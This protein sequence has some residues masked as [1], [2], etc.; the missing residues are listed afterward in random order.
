MKKICFFLLMVVSGLL[1]AQSKKS[2]AK[3]IIDFEFVT[4]DFGKV[5]QGKSVSHEFNFTNKGNAPLVLSNVQ[6]GCG[7]TTPEWPK[8]PIM[9]GQKSKIKAI[10]NPGSYKGKFGKG[11][12]VYSNADN[13]SVVLTIKGTVE[14][15]P[16]EPQSPVK[17]DV[18]G[19]F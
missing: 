17:I 5:Y 15:I 6:P 4:H 3:A 7:C 13:G 19:G 8:E 14:E 1:H 11:I 2:D 18:G 10:Y 12:T 16:T 9:P